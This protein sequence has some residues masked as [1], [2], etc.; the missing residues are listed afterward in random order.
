[1]REIA[2]R[3]AA[4]RPEWD[5]RVVNAF[6]GITSLNRI[7]L[8]GDLLAAVSLALKSARSD[9]VLVNGGEYAWPRMMRRHDR[10][11][12]IVV[13]H[14]T[15]AGEIPALVRAM[16]PA[17]R[18]YYHIEKWLGRWALL[19]RGQIAVSE[20]TQRELQ[21]AYGYRS[22]LRVVPNGS[23]TYLKPAEHRAAGRR[24]AWVGTHAFKKG[25]DI[26]L[27][28]CERARATLPDI[29]ML[30]IGIAGQSDARATWITYAGRL[31][32]A[33]SIEH[34]RSASILLAT[35][36]YEGCSVAVIEAL[37]LGIPIVAGPSVAWMVGEAGVPIADF[38][39]E[40]YADAIVGLLR[41]PGS[42]AA[43]SEAGP[44]RARLFDWNVAA[45]AYVAEVERCLA[46]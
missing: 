18:V 37:S 19:A 16:S 43:M 23:S 31:D 28:A 39:P 22:R 33:A 17:I 42:L 34:L 45:D 1:V 44:E 32:H 36:R 40:S 3:L 13:W 4:R 20:T 8:L 9:V 6:R 5:V 7:P 27:A 35:S 25:L 2:P 15:R 21:S 30:V 12:T 41:T 14:G 24:V 46:V 29:E 26:A 11:R 10:R 38:N